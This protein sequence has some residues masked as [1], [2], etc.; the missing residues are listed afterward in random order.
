MVCA[1]KDYNKVVHGSERLFYLCFGMLQSRISRRAA[2]HIK[3][4]I[5]N[6][7]YIGKM[8]NLYLPN[9]AAAETADKIESSNEV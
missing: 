9:K 5:G 6:T 2:G 1:K 8:Q 7:W 3:N 4:A